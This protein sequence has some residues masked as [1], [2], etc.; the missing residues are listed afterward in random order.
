MHPR[1]TI[2]L[3]IWITVLWP[4]YMDYC[5]MHSSQSSTRLDISSHIWP[6]RYIRDKPL[7]P[8]HR[9]C[10]FGKVCKKKKKK[11]F[12]QLQQKRWFSWILISADV[13]RFARVS[14]R[15]SRLEVVSWLIL[16]LCGCEVVF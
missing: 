10:Q 2:H 1:V 12:L 6:P 16:W 9:V 13:P 11:Y 14:P 15:S 4:A 5:D 8:L 7:L 3:K